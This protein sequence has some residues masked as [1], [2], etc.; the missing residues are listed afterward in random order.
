MAPSA[1]SLE[2]EIVGVEAAPDKKQICEEVPRDVEELTT[3]DNIKGMKTLR[4]LTVPMT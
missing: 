4:S 1:K 2:A 3:L